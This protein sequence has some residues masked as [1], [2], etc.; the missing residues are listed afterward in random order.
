MLPS[1]RLV[2]AAAK[3]GGGRV[4]VSGGQAG[5][6]QITLGPLHRR[7]VPR[8]AGIDQGEQLAGG[9]VVA[10]L[11]SG[12][13]GQRPCPAQPLS[14]DPEHGSVGERGARVAQY[15]LGLPAGGGDERFS[16]A[17]HRLVLH[18]VASPQVR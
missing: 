14:A 9:V 2:T 1:R 8:P 7:E 15:V 6:N 11:A 4:P 17:D 3:D 5:A 18:V 16:H 12:A 10:Q 13:G